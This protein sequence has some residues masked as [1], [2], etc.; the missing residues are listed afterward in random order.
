MK[1]KFLTL[2]SFILVLTMLSG[3]FAAC[4]SPEETTAEQTTESKADESTTAE[5]TQPSE[6]PTTA[7]PKESDPT[8]A[9]TTPDTGESESASE[10]D[11]DSTTESGSSTETES[12]EESD[13]VTV[14]KIES[15]HDDLIGTANGLANGVQAYFPNAKRTHYTLMNQEMSVN[16][17]RSNQYD[18]LVESIKNTK[19]AA[20]I[21]NT[22]DVFVRMVGDPETHYA[23]QSNKSAEVNLYRFGYYYYEAFF[24]YQDFVPKNFEILDPVEIDVTK[25]YSST[26]GTKRGTEDGNRAYTITD[27]F[28]PRIMYEKDFNYA[29]VDNNVF[30]IKAKALGDTSL[31][32]LFLKLDG[33]RNYNQSRSLTIPLINDGEYH[34]Y[35]FSLYTIADY[36]GNILGLRLDPNGSVGGGIAIE[37]MTLGKAEL[38]NVP[39]NLSINRHFHVY[40]DKMHHAVQFAATQK[41]ENIAEIG[42]ETKIDADT[43]S[44]IIVVAQDGKKLVTYDSLDAGF[45]WDDV[46]A[47]GFDVTEAGIFGFILPDD[48]ISGKIKVELKDGIYVIEQTRVPSVDGVDGVIIPSIDTENRDKDGNLMHAE[49]VVNNGNDVYISQRVYTDENHDFAE[50]IMETGFERFPDGVKGNVVSSKSSSASYAG[51][52]PMRGI[53]IFNI[54]TPA[55][56]FYT[57]YNTPNKQ[58]KINFQFKTDVDRQIYVMSYGK[59]GL[60]ECATLM[61]ENMMLLPI[62]IEVIKNFSESTGERNLYN[63][64]DPTFSEAI[65]CLDL[66]A[67]NGKQEY[68]IINLYQNWGKYPLKQLSQIPFH[69][70]YYHLSTGVTETNCILPWFGTANVGKSFT[71]STLPDFRSMSAP[72]W[73]SQPQHNSCGSHSWLVYTDSEGGSY[74]VEATRQNIT[75]YGP[76]YAEVVWENISDDGKIKV[77]YTHMEMPQV[78]ENRSYYTMEYEFLDTLTINNFKDNFRFYNVT[79][80][81][82][83]GTYK[84]V[85]YLNENNESVVVDSNQN[86]KA[87]PEYVLGDN[88]PYFSF[89]M[90]PDWNRESTSAEG[91]ANA[92][93]LIYNSEFIIGGAEKDYNFL[94]KN[95]K[96]NVTLTLN[97][98]ETVTF[99]A[100]DKITINAILLPWGSQELEDDPANRLNQAHAT[101]YTEY[102]YS[103]VLPD[104]TLYMDKN[105]RDVRENTLLNPLTVTSETDEI[106]DSVYLPKVKSSDGKTAEFT[107]SGGENNVTVRVYGFARLTAPKVEEFVDGEWVEYILSSKEE[108]ANN[109]HYH[110]YDGY[111]VFYDE[112]GT[113]SYS[114]VTTMHDG[115]PRKFR[116]SADEE[117]VEWPREKDPPERS[118]ALNIYTDYE[119]LQDLIIQS[120][121]MYGTP[122]VNE[123]DGN[124]FVSVF[125]K[126]ENSFGESYSTLH[127]K[128][129]GAVA[130]GQYLVIK[131]RVPK[132]NTED[133]G[134]FQIWAS[135]E[136]TSAVEAGSFSYTPVADG[137]W[138]VDVIDLSKTGLKSY[139]ANDSGEFVTKLL[140]VDIFNKQFTDATTHI[141]IAYIGIDSDLTKICEL[142]QEKFKTITLVEDNNKSELDTATG[143]PFIRTYIDPES[144]YTKSSLPFGSIIDSIN[145]VAVKLNNYSVKNG[146]STYSMATVTK[147]MKISLAGWACVEGGVNRYVWSVDGGKTWNDFPGQEKLGKASDAMIENTEGANKTPFSDAAASKNN[148]NFQATTVPLTADL[149]AYQGQTVDITI[150]AVPA[151][152]T[153][154]LV[155]LYHFE[156]V[157]CSYES[158]F[159][160]ESIYLEAPVLFSSQIDSVN[161]TENIKQASNLTGLGTYTDV[162]VSGNTI[163]FKGW[164]AVD[165]G[166]AKYVWT[167]DNGATWYDCGGKAYAPANREDGTCAIITVGEKRT[168]GT[169]ADAEA[170]KKNAG[171]QGE[172]I[173]IDLSAY[174]GTTKPLDIYLCAVTDTNQGRVVILYYLKGVVPPAAAQ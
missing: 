96:D 119:E 6:E 173:T 34:T 156:K 154:T 102:T 49:G 139:T 61:D 161:G 98:S 128:D 78:D 59:G 164:A 97:T 15:P 68:N 144:G 45:S 172:G 134:H 152:D 106:I 159:A 41:T 142:E 122:S 71:S 3:A 107:L 29:T 63:I 23:S 126:L 50:F 165:G 151:A 103:T 113:Y 17:A 67:D 145:G 18:Q 168:G 150:A 46:V 169:F 76:T 110:Y 12:E 25:Q 147:D 44:S 16:Y 79:D 163:L 170:T 130:A 66:K 77:T 55:G 162:T 38:G 143:L 70:P 136:T 137:A 7:A 104:G 121:H 40:S 74:A 51:Y 84:K 48:D 131:Y 95:P 135:T 52:D 14:E 111:M 127:M 19:G 20:Y 8:E 22:M 11:T 4:T 37:S 88:C 174:A 30:A 24:E 157:E 105:V 35:Y 117:F 33:N 112:D 32:Q 91:Y 81:N 146:V 133:V 94:I 75:S 82:G 26:V 141:D 1:R 62:P 86:D 10:T 138:H 90:M 109:D 64:S 129:E 2:L 89:F 120:S 155:L 100:G 166:V 21:Q 80:N 9:T 153:D 27:S 13:P 158:I 118:N 54:E 171:F 73:K 31:I 28:D 47:V 57:P 5:K 99:Q 42:M 69:C 125:V 56:G 58:Y 85:G 43:V 160:D 114:F 53:Y 167:A 115:A 87:V 36:T 93:L 116:I 83:T 108:E 132:A 124:S 149:S 60:L 92:A 72:Y 39:S 65:F 140:R 101:G 148:G 123:E